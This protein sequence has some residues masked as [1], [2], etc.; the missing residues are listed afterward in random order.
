M[1]IWVEKE[2]NN[3]DTGD[4]R[5]N[6]RTK[7]VLQSIINK[8]NMSFTQQFQSAKELKACYRLFDSDLI[9]SEVILDPH[10]E[11]TIERIQDCKLVVIASDS[12]S[13]NYTTR[14]SNPDSGYISSN[15]AQGFLM[16]ISLATTLD[17]QPLGV[18]ETKFWARSK[19]K[20]LKK[21]HRD[22]LPIEE[23]ESY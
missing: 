16:H 7:F 14:L 22:Y 18:L 8:P 3:L 10:F 19:E 21:V 20:P 4:E 5:L 15:N 17:R 6:K 23:K 11:K 12:S 2:M 9:N 13:L 1:G